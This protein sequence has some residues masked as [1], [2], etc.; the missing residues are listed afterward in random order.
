MQNLKTIALAAL[1]LIASGANASN[2]IANG[3]FETPGVAGYA[4]FGSDYIKGGNAYDPSVV[5]IGSNPIDFHGGWA[6]F[7]ALSGSGMLIVNGGTDGANNVVWSQTLNLTAGTYDF[8][9]SA[10]STYGG[11]PSKLQAVVNVLGNDYPLGGPVQLGSS[12]GQWQ[13]LSGQVTVP[14]NVSVQVKLLNLS[15]DYSGNDFALD[16]ISLTAAVPEPET[17]ALMLA[18]LAAVGFVARRRQSN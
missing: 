12:T 13:A 4:A 11:N 18:G 7:N 6:S 9:G 17:Y 14:F 2:L 16:A 5:N 10:A 15:T 1:A 8:S 3:D